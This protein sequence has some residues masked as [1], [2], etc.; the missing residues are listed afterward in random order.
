VLRPPPRR[1][2]QVTW[3]NVAAF[4][5]ATSSAMYV[6]DANAYYAYMGNNMVIQYDV[7]NG[8]MV[9]GACSSAGDWWQVDLGGV[10]HGERASQQCL[11]TQAVG[12]LW[13]RLLGAQHPTTGL[14]RTPPR[15]QVYNLSTV[16][17]YNRWAFASR[18]VGSSIQ[19]FNSYGTLIGNQ[20]L[21]AGA[22]QVYP[23][24]TYLPSPSATTSRTPSMTAS[25][26]RTGTPTGTSTLTPGVSASS[27]PSPSTTA[28]NS[29]TST[30]TPTATVSAQ[31][32]VAAKLLLADVPGTA[33]SSVCLNFVEL[34][35]R[36]HTN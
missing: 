17:L 27:T 12:S 7:N 6:G 25:N 10:S 35:V 5:N 15:P 16:V 19:Y 36:D 23:V 34:L 14:L 8:D 1:P 28:S 4:K 29:A 21:N 11:R 22:I 18:I 33:A 3:T 24:A 13:H 32:P 31:Y 20:T 26:T 2:L 9:N 30:P